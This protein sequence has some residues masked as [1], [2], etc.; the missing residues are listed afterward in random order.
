MLD[1]LKLIHERDAQDALGVV[2][3]QWQQLTHEFGVTFKPTAEI[4][5]IVL[6]GMGGSGWP[7]TYV[8][9]WPGVSV[10]FEISN[11]YTVPRYVDGHTLFI[12]SSYSGN[13]EE[14]LAAL[15]DAEA[16][17][18]QIVV[19]TSGG[20]LKELAEQ[21]GY[22]LY[23][24][25][26]GTQPRMSSFYFIAAFLELF[27]PLGLVDTDAIKQRQGISDWLKAQTASWRPDTPT[28]QNPAKQLAQELMG[29]T[30]IVYSGP[31]LAPVAQKI[32]ICM[33]ENAKNLAWWNQYPE[34][35]HN[36][37]IGWSSHPVD[38]PFAVIEIRSNLEHERVQKR[39][40]VTEK[41]LSGKRPSP[42]VIV[43]QGDTLPK[44]I[45]WASVFGDFVSLYLALLNGLN[46]TP[47]DLVEKFKQALDA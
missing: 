16:R 34:F 26:T 33:N 46:P 29:K 31:L 21:K 18:A 7:A 36:E 27:T 39:F 32:K 28:A 20:K 35:N 45:F 3:K 12:A 23:V 5:N 38:K 2:E 14:T 8:Q 6:G 10:P 19:M 24:L 41:M 22:P 47:V 44:Q 40:E 11:N 43:P 42:H 17:K 15:A 9:S 4:R 30:V 13:T 25:P 1:D 37:F